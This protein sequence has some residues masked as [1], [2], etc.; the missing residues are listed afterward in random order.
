MG[1]Q[2]ASKRRKLL[3]D[4]DTDL[5]VPVRNESP[6]PEWTLRPSDNY[7]HFIRNK[8]K[9]RICLSF[10][11]RNK[12]NSGCAFQHTHL[13]ELSQKNS[14]LMTEFVKAVRKA[15]GKKDTPGDV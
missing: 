6:V 13:E 5:C 12:C 14:N 8:K 11:M 9:P 15:K 10:W 7:T 1:D 4:T 2:G 3:G